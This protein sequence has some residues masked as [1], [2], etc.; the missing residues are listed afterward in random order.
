LSDTTA[1]PPGK[2][3]RTARLIARARATL[4]WERVWPA[5]WPAAGFV[6]LF[7]GAA[8]FG[9]FAKLPW[10]LHALIL[11]A[12]TVAVAAS[13]YFTFANFR[14]PDWHQG[15]RRVERDSQLNHRPLSESGDTLAVG[16]GDS[17][18]EALWRAHILRLL[19]G[20]QRLRVALPSPGLPKRDPYALRFLVLLFVIA[21]FIF[22]G[23]E[24]SSRIV[25]ALRVNPASG[26]AVPTLDAWVNP[27]SYTGE[28]P[29]YLQRGAP[30]VVAVPT[31]STL[32]LRV[33]GSAYEPDLSFGGEGGFKG[34]QGNY[35]ANVRITS[36]GRV[37]VRADGAKLGS[38]RF[39]AI[40]DDK[41]VIAFS[42]KPTRTQRDALKISFTAGDDY[43]VVSVKAIIRPTGKNKSGKPLIVDLPLTSASAKAMNQTVFRDLTENPYAG[44]PV[45]ITLTAKDGAGQ[46]GVSKPQFITLP[47]RIFTNP[48]SRA[49]IEQRQ[50]LAAQGLRARDHT[51]LALNA[52][53]IAPDLFYPDHTSTYTAL[54]SA[55]WAL[56]I[57]QRPGDLARVEDLLWQT[58]VALEHGGLM[59]AAQ[60]LRELQQMIADAL[61]RGAPQSEIDALLD[62]YRQAMQRYM[63]QLAQN[64]GGQQ[65]DLPP[66]TKTL[67]QDDLN[68]LIKMIQQL[69]QTGSREQAQQLMALL[70]NLLENMRIANGSG[71]QG[72]GAQ[73]PGNKA[74]S[75]AIQGLGDML[76]RQ[77]GLLD[78]TYRQ[79]QGAGDP[80]DGGPQGLA[81]QQGQ[82]RQDLDKVLKGL[83][84]QNI[85]VPNSLNR[86]GRGMGN[87]QQDLQGNNT[88]GASTEQQNTI[89]AL[90]QGADE[91]A[92]NLMK[93]MGQQGQNG[94][95]NEDPLGRAQGA[96]GPNVGG[97]VKIPGRSD[98]QR[99]RD[100]LKEL[101]R[102]AAERGRP[103][104][105]LDYID[106][107]LKQF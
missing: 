69:A 57:S 105:E 11:S 79:G 72:S 62:R 34:T 56:K 28:A 66:G 84:A 103:Q 3:D 70:Q 58:A 101:R 23:T 24:W 71:G 59:L 13:L 4:L 49:L 73:S 21:G 96:T 18:A 36:D 52:L 80:K 15:A 16:A 1:F 38:W 30:G 7:L 89:D 42:A 78:K 41:P 55:Y 74:M 63:Q 51:A 94:G 19:A 83:G 95:Q 10:Q 106:R 87:S 32:A 37:R 29:I 85:P 77:R 44:L 60:E 2:A 40:P 82:L 12:L 104:E 20:L 35:S 39:K 81:Q 100:I 25:T 26:L 17:M 91:L 64:G 33:H 98:L 68:A 61:A 14:M 90:R 27:P 46:I 5:L 67:S 88:D 31:G 97:G 92:K 8:L 48:L 102:R 50:N 107:L 45:Q 6:G 53:T 93:A 54:R 76:G 65:G 75:D 22:A 99:A 86:A 43:G 9:L 47:A